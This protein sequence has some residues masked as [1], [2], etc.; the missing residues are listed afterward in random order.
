MVNGEWQGLNGEWRISPVHSPFT[1]HHS[2]GRRAAA[3]GAHPQRRH[4]QLQECFLLHALGLTK[5]GP[6][7]AGP[8]AL[9]VFF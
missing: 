3:V 4:K 7:S 1:I 8:I 9:E 5:K 2:R 6:A